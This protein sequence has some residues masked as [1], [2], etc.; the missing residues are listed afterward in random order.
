MRILIDSGSYH[1]LNVGDVAMLQ[2]GVERLRELWPSASIAAV[3][4][5][6]VAGYAG[7]NGGDVDAI[8]PAVRRASMHLAAPLVPVPIA[9]HPDCHDGVAIREL[10]AEPGGAPRSSS[11]HRG[12]L[13][14]VDPGRREPNGSERCRTFRDDLIRERSRL[15]A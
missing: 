14:R 7:A 8:R 4:S 6:R 2:T 5:V 13:R 1:A 11:R 10:L 9:H 15:R 3:T 12:S